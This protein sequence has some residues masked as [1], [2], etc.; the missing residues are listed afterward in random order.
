MTTPTMALFDPRK[1]GT[2]YEP[3]MQ[4]AY[5]MGVADFQTPASADGT[6][7]L[8]WLIDMQVDF[9]FPAPIGN[10]SVPGAVDDTVRTVDWLYRNAHQITQI[11]ASLDTH[12]PFQIFYPSWWKNSRGERPAPFT[13]ISADD[14]RKGIWTPITEPIWSIKYL[15]ELENV[16][17]KQLMIWPFHCMEGSTG[18]A[19]VPALTEAIMYH[20]GARMAQPTFLTKG[21]IA[22]T[23]FYSV[24]EPEVKYP[25]HPDG[26][27][28]TRFLEMV[29]Q[30]D[31][32][33]VAGQARS[34]CVLETMNSVVRHFAAH[35]EVIRK[36]RF[37]DD[38]TSSIPGFEKAT[39]A[40]IQQFVA[41]G[42]KLVKSTDKI[43]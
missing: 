42:V 6:R 10:L 3:N 8:A 37:L 21:T 14:V 34:H 32:I 2:M 7:V 27:L 26:G 28:N 31:L 20:S 43:G 41:K 22:H 15:D 19:L 38:C 23:E 33:Y 18:R 9:V 29:A 13:A 5:E 24:V 16:G 4:R 30:F 1:V 25:K 39:E 11:A 12:T 17:K 35:P 40:A 36:L